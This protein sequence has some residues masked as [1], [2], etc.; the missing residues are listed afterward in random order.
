MSGEVISLEV[1]KSLIQCY[2]NII[3]NF[4]ELDTM[5]VSFLEQVMVFFS[6]DACSIILRQDDESNLVV[7]L[8][9]GISSVRK[10]FIEKGTLASWVFEHRQSAVLNDPLGD[11]R[12]KKSNNPR[13]RN[14][15][16]SPVLMDGDCVGVLELFNKISGEFHGQ[17]IVLVESL[18]NFASLLYK[19]YLDSKDR[20][21]FLKSTAYSA[22]GNPNLFVGSGQII[23]EV[24]R[25]VE[26]LAKT[27]ATVLINGEFGSGKKVFARKLH[28]KSSRRDCP[29]VILSCESKS[30]DQLEKEIF[31]YS[32]EN[33]KVPGILENCVGGTFV[34]DE[35]ACLPIYLQK[36]ILDIIQKKSYFNQ[37]TNEEV[38]LNLR[39]VVLEKEN[40][41]ALVDKKLFLEELYYQLNVLPLNIPP[42]R[43]HPDDIKVLS[44]LYL[45]NSCLRHH[46]SIKGFSQEAVNLLENYEW[47]GNLLE[48]ENLVERAVLCCGTDLIKPQDFMGPVDSSKSSLSL[49]SAVE[50]LVQNDDKTLKAAVDGFKKMYIEKILKENKWNQTLAAKVLDVQRTYVSRL[51][52][53]LDIKRN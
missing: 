19:F 41:S 45:N 47:P 52:S 38:T 37:W 7:S 36:K 39:I 12:F 46:K 14:I 4:S 35:V 48:L 5:L 34:I 30:S 2:S 49:D 17:D 23:R 24:E 10:T 53:E 18:G 51:I 26:E 33:K 50:E 8:N 31:G 25:T 22:K 28:E 40:L 11:T 15:L 3:R 21:E 16:A 6:C 44:R 9:K 43:K 42:L 20:D 29:F 27:N 13:L 1:S 32:T